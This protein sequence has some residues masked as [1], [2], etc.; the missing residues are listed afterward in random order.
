MGCAGR[1]ASHVGGRYGLPYGSGGDRSHCGARI[2]WNIR[3]YSGAG[4][5]VCGISVMVE[6]PASL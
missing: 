5:V 1:R 4:R 3:L 2:P 6:Q